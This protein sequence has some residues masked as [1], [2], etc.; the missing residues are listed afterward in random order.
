MEFGELSYWL[1]A[2]SEY[3]QKASEPAGG[4]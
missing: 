2:V 4:G 1:A 3:N